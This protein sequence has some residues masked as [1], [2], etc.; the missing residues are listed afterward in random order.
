MERNGSTIPND[1]NTK[2]TMVDVLDKYRGTCYTVII[3]GILII[4]WYIAA[5]RIQ[6]TLLLPY[7]QETAREF[8]HAWVDPKIMSN[9][10][11]TLRRVFT[12]FIYAFIIGIPVGLLMGYSQT[13]MQA[14]SPVINSVRQVPIMAWVPLSIIWFGLGDGPTV[15]LIT[16]S[17]VFPLVINTIVGVHGIDPN[18]YNAARSM[19]ASLPNIIKD[20]V[21]PAA[22]PNILTGCRLAMGS[23]WMSVICAEFIATSAGFGFL[24]V[25]AQVRLET[26]QLYALMFMSGLVGF[27][28]DKGF[29]TLE[30]KITA[31][32]FKDGFAGN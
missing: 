4:A 7:F 31:W 14:I 25:E 23:G 30:K 2:V 27:A 6:N 5:K 22:I 17:A 10:A 1:R 9:L 20:I 18:Y 8:F 11:L 29:I 26:A 15:F 32:R 28:I 19:G 21:V 12:G 13:A 24:M 16:M 3:V